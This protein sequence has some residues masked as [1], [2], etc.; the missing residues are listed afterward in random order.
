MNSHKNIV[1]ARWLR[2][3]FGDPNLRILDC[4]SDLGDA[5]AGRRDY[6]QGHIP[7][8]L[9]IDLEEDLSGE[10]TDSSGRHPLPEVDA[11]ER[12]LG[13]L[14][15][16]SGTHVIVYDADNGALASRAWWILR[17]LGHRRVS[18]LDGGIAGWLRHGY[19][20]EAGSAPLA[21]RR[22][23]ARP[24]DDLV[25]TTAEIV[26]AMKTNRDLMLIDARDTERFLGEFE[27]IDPVAGHIPGACSLPLGQ[28][29]DEDL[30]WKPVEDLRAIWNEQ[31]GSDREVHWA[32]MCGSGVTACHLAISGIEAGFREPRLYVG[33]WSEWIRDSERPVVQ[34]NGA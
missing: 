30:T 16:D 3:Q 10:I 9:F 33:S 8:A 12:R 22:F 4:R 11:I 19:G 13:Q 15:I 27:P 5:L 26:E 29:L 17:W 18:L 6:L 2:S 7:G 24:R 23:A 21:E 14:G 28:S 34:G 31:L 20:L 32:V 1:S 25:L